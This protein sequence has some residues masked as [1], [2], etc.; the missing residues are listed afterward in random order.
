M[1]KNKNEIQEELYKTIEVVVK[2]VLTTL[3][4]ITVIEGQIVEVDPS[5][6]YYK[7][8]YQDS[9]DTAFSIN[10]EIFEVGDMVY[11][12]T[13]SGMQMK[14]LILTKSNSYSNAINLK[15]QQKIYSSTGK[16]DNSVGNDGDV[17]I[18]Y[19]ANTYIEVQ[20]SRRYPDDNLEGIEIFVGDKILRTNRY[21]YAKLAIEPGKY[22]LSCADTGTPLIEVNVFEN[23]RNTVEL[24]TLENH[25]YG[26][27]FI[28]NSR[29]PVLKRTHD[30]IG[31]R[32]RV[33]EGKVANPEI[34]NDFNGYYPWCMMRP[35][36]IDS[37][38]RRKEGVIE[39]NDKVMVCIPKFYLDYI[40]NEHCYISTKPKE[41]FRLPK[42][43]I[44]EDG[45]IRSFIYVGAFLSSGSGA[46]LTSQAGKSIA[47]SQARETYRK[48]C[49]EIGVG[50]QMTDAT[51]LFEVMQPMLMVEFATLD[52][53]TIA[54]DYSVGNNAAATGATEACFF[55]SGSAISNYSG[56]D[57]FR[58][59]HIENPWGNGRKF[60][61]G[62]NLKG[63]KA[64]VCCNPKV[65][66]EDFNSMHYALL[67]Y[68]YTNIQGYSFSKLGYDEKLPYVFLP[69]ENS[70]M[71]GGV[72]GN[73][74]N[75]VG[76][77]APS[78]AG[79]AA[80]YPMLT[81]TASNNF[82]A[83]PFSLW[84]STNNA[85]GGTTIR[86]SYRD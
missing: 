49:A 66:T 85:D 58:W 57:H 45:S 29:S 1:D 41:G 26:V 73:S 10:T 86:L 12:I 9:I 65:Y 60:I 7:Y 79:V 28:K 5:G 48:W 67:G 31:A 11:I 3:P 19:S 78:G 33:G 53:K 17:W 8:S 16:P 38:G 15:E 34:I 43:F 77:F 4:F 56:K 82:N 22:G 72:T 69:I 35:M 32:A 14:K 71:S 51:E 64:V 40:P 61:D 47:F 75:Y 2:K 80:K 68:Q 42:A 21:G 44:R 36:S 81:T 13:S 20:I 74:T 52:L 55:N 59:R 70:K 84:F 24:V 27:D 37:T 50:W 83:S 25:I 39:G 30:A 23:E 6:N 18:K 62:I 46:N 54:Y 63:E 76:E